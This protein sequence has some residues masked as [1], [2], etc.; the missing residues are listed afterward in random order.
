MA[1]LHHRPTALRLNYTSQ[2][3]LVD[4]WL[5]LTPE[6]IAST[7]V[8]SSTQKLENWGMDLV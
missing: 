7:M 2:T 4:G 8:I 5:N 3:Y 6:T 1:K